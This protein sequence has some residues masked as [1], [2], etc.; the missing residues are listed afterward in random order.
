MKTF[1]YLIIAAY[2]LLTLFTGIYKG[3]RIKNVQEFT[4]SRG[5][6]TTTALVATIFGTIIGGGATMDPLTK[7]FSFGALFF[8][9]YLGMS[10]SKLVMS[11][12]LAPRFHR[13]RSMISM[14]D[15][16]GDGY[17]KCGKVITGIAGFWLLSGYVGA[18][19]SACSIFI[20]YFTGISASVC[21]LISTAIVVFYSAF[22]GIRSVTAT[23]VVQ[24]IVIIVAFPLI[25]HMALH[26]VG[27]WQ[28]LYDSLPAEKLSFFPEDNNT[29]FEFF[30][31]FIF[32]MPFMNPA[33]IQRLLMAEST[34]QTIKSFRIAA[35]VDV[36]FYITITIIAL[37]IFA[38]NPSLDSAV[39]L[40]YMIENHLPVMLK[41][42]AVTGIL[43][44]IMSSADSFL[45]SASVLL[46]HDFVKPLKK[47]ALTDRQ[48]LLLIRFS[49]IIIGM[50]AAGSA[51]YFK[52]VLAI[53][54]SFAK[55][56]IPVVLVPFVAHVFGKAKD[57]RTFLVA[58]AVGLI[59]A[60]IWDANIKVINSVFP[61]LLVNALIFFLLPQ[62]AKQKEAITA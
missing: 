46:V 45:N 50:L 4:V 6:F 58:G 33:V 48:E 49:T 23:D 54:F 42:L 35:L 56:W 52:N 20:S 10:F 27:G 43:A 3:R 14:G 41:G 29:W 7:I 34:E 21:V 44:V 22:G 17:G 40:P 36:P 61:S 5:N 9:P 12:F 1:D 39:V 16:M 57:V 31:V 38:L 60:F 37:S 51:L 32:C 47:E 30:K 55:V 18:Q 15:I 19:I 2:L 28:G 25:A 11:E 62:R 8:L 24:F 59:F 26:E 53:H 13:F